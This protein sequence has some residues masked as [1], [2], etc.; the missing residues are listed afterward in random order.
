MSH[1][2]TERDRQAGTSQAW[3]GK[4]LVAD[5]IT[6]ENSM[7]YEVIEADIFYKVPDATMGIASD[8]GNF[9][10][11]EDMKQLIASDDFLPIGMPYG[12]SYKPTSIGT[13]WNVIDKGMGT[14]P[15]E[16]VSAGSI[17]NR[18]KIFAS[19]KLTDGFQ[20]GGREFKDYITVIDSFDK[21]TSFKVL[22]S[23]ICVVCANTYA[24]ALSA[25]GEV[26]RAKHT[27]NVDDNIVRLIDAIKAFVNVSNQNQIQLKAAHLTDCS[28]DEARAW[29]MG[30]ETRGNKEITNALVQ[31]S[32]RMMELFNHGKGNQGQ[33]RLDAFSA[34]TEFH[35]HE[36]SNRKGPN[37]QSYASEWGTSARMKA[38]AFE[39][40]NMGWDRTVKAGEEVLAKI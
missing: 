17:D 31:K 7:P 39:S 15:Y 23:N 37:A 9:I 13:F 20:V 19:L 35:T 6:R 25:G 32:A 5:K 3:H 8:D 33:T 14:T 24:A 10:L 11:A 22:Y 28:Q 1:G 12:K 2:I 36:S 21:T 40:L 34:Y 4:T 16:V 26:A 30:L 18:G 38:L 27:V 29:L